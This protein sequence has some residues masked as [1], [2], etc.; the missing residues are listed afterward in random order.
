MDRPFDELSDLAKRIADGELHPDMGCCD[1][2]SEGDRRFVLGLVRYELIERDRKPRQAKALALFLSWLTPEQ[3]RRAS[4]NRTVIIQGSAGGWYRLQP[5]YGQTE[6]VERHGSKFWRIGTFC[7][8]DDDGMPNADVALGHLLLILTDEPRFR[9]EANF[10]PSWP[11]C[12]DKDYMRKRAEIRRRRAAGDIEY[13]PAEE[14][15]IVAAELR[16][17]ETAAA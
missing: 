15:A 8:H 4:R 17:T 7:Y 3:R 6:L 9:A 11:Q 14:L 1:H 5:W 2:L 10:T 16:G 12:W 13:D